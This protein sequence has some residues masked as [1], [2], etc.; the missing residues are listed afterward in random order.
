MESI[1]FSNDIDTQFRLVDKTL[2]LHNSIH[3]SIVDICSTGP[4]Q[5]NYEVIFAAKQNLSK[6][7]IKTE[8]DVN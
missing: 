6:N 5:V 3:Q 4:N 7:G 1:R 8:R 2:N